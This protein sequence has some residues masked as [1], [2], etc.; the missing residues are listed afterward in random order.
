MKCVAVIGGG[1]AAAFLVHELIQQNIKV[2]WWDSGKTASEAGVG[3][4]NPLTGQRMRWVENAEVLL[5]NF[6]NFFQTTVGSTLRHYW[7]HTP[8][9][10]P[11]LNEKQRTYW[12]Q[13]WKQWHQWLTFQDKPVE[14]VK[15]PY[16][17]LWVKGATWIRKPF[18]NHFKTLLRRHAE[19]TFYPHFCPYKAI[20]IDQR[21]VFHHRVD[22][23][24]FCEGA[25]FV[26]N[27][28][29]RYLHP[30]VS[31]LPGQTL[32]L[33]L[34][35]CTWHYGLIYQGYF[36]P[37]DKE[38]FLIG[39]TYE[40]QRVL[41]PSE[42]TEQLLQKL[43]LWFT[44]VPLHRVLYVYRGVRLTPR[45]YQPLVGCHRQYPWLFVLTALGTKGLLYAPTAAKALVRY[46]LHQTP[47]PSQWDVKRII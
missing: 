7:E 20:D 8:I 3:L 28:L 15:N 38:R 21:K 24:F 9:Y 32:M 12:K 42:A 23:I 46:W 26:K 19:V 5:Q 47:L 34:Q 1:F 6:Q 25:S 2:Y 22:A 4:C 41:T 43:A 37:W 30:F 36:I 27:P 33:K 29:F 16:G 35:N 31:C 18:L 44:K 13:H 14:N 17:G 45:D 39:A 11:F 10:R 40:R